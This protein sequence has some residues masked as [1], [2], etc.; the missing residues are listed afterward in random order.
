MMAGQLQLFS[1]GMMR[2]QTYLFVTLL[3]RVRQPNSNK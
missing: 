2:A 1:G 3:S